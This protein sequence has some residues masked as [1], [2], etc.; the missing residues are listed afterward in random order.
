MTLILDPNW[1]SRLQRHNHNHASF[2]F[3]GNI[4][5][6]W[7]PV[8]KA[9]KCADLQDEEGDKH[10]MGGLV[11]IR[12]IMHYGRGFF[13]RFHRDHKEKKMRKEKFEIFFC[14]EAQRS[15]FF[16]SFFPIERWKDSFFFGPKELA[17]CSSLLLF[18]IAV[19]EEAVMFL[20]KSTYLSKKQAWK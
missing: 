17:S 13:V 5:G 10:A 7:R 8:L 19:K 3:L 1:F 15:S 20:Q 12:D 2:F 18:F 14:G 4:I 9:T 16:S 6:G 11:H